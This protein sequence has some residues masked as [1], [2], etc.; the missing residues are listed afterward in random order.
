MVFYHKIMRMKSKSNKI[1]S[2]LLA[3]VLAL[4]MM[5]GV[6]PMS[7]SAAYENTHSNTGNQ[8]IDIVEIAKPR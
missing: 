1:F 8:R 5:I 3:L 2:G 6:I 7:A 4:T